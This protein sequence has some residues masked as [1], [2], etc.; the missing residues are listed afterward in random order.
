MVVMFVQRLM[1]WRSSITQQPV[2]SGEM[3]SVA[4]VPSE[5]L[6]HPVLFF[7]K[8]TFYSSIDWVNNTNQSED[9]TQASQVNTS[10]DQPIVGGVIPHHLLPS[11]MI[12]DF[13]SRLAK[14]QPKTIILIGPNHNEAGE[15]PILTSLYSW[16][17]PFGTVSPD[18]TRI[19]LLLDRQIAWQDESTLPKD[20]SVA[21]ILPFVEYYLPNVA[22]VPLLLSGA[23]SDEELQ[24]L[25]RGLSELQEGEQGGIILIAAVDFSHYLTSAQAEEKDAITLNL[26]RDFQVERLLNLN[27]DYLDSPESIAVLLQVMQAGEST[28]MRVFHHTNSGA[29]TKNPFAATTSY[30]ALAYY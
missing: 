11:Y 8:T 26:M 15:H 22:V 1:Q 17:T 20:H 4:S 16:E 23:T 6:V 29:L 24:K 28:K 9:T 3:Q 14:Q 18:T 27:S 25:A 5:T 7:D 2:S 30:F 21:G 19:Q 12:A 13:F 10:F